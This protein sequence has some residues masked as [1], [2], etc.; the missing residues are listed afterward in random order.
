MAAVQPTRTLVVLLVCP[1]KEAA[2]A[3]SGGLV[4]HGV[5]HRPA[6]ALTPPRG[7]D[8]DQVEERCFWSDRPC[9]V[10]AAEGKACRGLDSGAI[11]ESVR[12]MA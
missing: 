3:P 5:E 10:V 8:V 12:V 2:R 1:Q 6:D 4:D 11:L 9:S 7:Q